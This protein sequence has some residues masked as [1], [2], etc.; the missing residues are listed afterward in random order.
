MRHTMG[1]PG[2]G[3]HTVLSLFLV[4]G[5]LLLLQVPAE[6]QEQTVLTVLNNGKAPDSPVQVSGIDNGGK[7]PL[8]QTGADGTASFDPSFLDVAEGTPVIVYVRT[9]EDG[10]VEV[11]LVPEGEEDGD[12]CAGEDTEEGARCDCEEVGVFAWGDG[13][14]VIDVG[15]GTVSSGGG[16]LLGVPPGAPGV[17]FGFKA[18][19]VHWTE[20]DDAV[21]GQSNLVGC[22]VDEYSLLLLPFAEVRLGPLPVSLGVAGSY[23]EV[24]F[25]QEFDRSS[26]PRLPGRVDGKMDVWSVE[27][28]GRLG[29]W[30]NSWL[31]PYVL[32]GTAWILN[33]A[34]FRPTVPDGS[35]MEERDSDGFRFRAGG[36]LDALVLGSLGLRFNVDYLSGGSDDAD[37]QIRFGGGFLVPL[38]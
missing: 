16:G 28:Y 29:W 21:C 34:E 15:T 18:D 37:S 36:G 9:C 5:G 24:D 38:F 23:S 11:I 10:H 22:E 19:G 1:A 32:A 27:G 30:V 35:V 20:F 6:G 13:N 7:Q 25:R 12:P 33:S 14:V 8:T 4:L 26:D 3:R 2:A 17:T 31:N